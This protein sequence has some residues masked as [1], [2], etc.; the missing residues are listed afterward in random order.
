VLV[1]ILLLGS[2]LR[3]QRVLGV[4]MYPLLTEGSPQFLG[5]ENRRKVGRL[6]TPLQGLGTIVA[7]G[8]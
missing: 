7:F 6:L 1:R 3:A 4:P 8:V 2:R 5:Y